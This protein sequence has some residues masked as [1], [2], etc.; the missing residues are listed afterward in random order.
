MVLALSRMLGHMVE[1]YIASLP[2]LPL[3]WATALKNADLV[4]GKTSPTIGPLKGAVVGMAALAVPIVMQ[5]REC[6]REDA[7]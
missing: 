4:L 2:D 1:P 7:R 5:V 6:E 3:D